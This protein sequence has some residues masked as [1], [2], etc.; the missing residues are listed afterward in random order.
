MCWVKR[1]YTVPGLRSW[2]QQSSNS[3][4][5]RRHR[6][7]W[8]PPRAAGEA[9]LDVLASSGQAVGAGVSRFEDAFLSGSSRQLEACCAHTLSLGPSLLR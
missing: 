3:C 4:P 8:T 7:L 1:V 6:R 5:E 9:M 2:R